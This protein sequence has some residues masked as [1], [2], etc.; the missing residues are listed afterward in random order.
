M[1]Q[2][3]FRLFIFRF[4]SLDGFS[5]FAFPLFLRN[6]TLI[7]TYLFKSLSILGDKDVKVMCPTD[8]N[9]PGYAQPHTPVQVSSFY[10][11]LFVRTGFLLFFLSLIQKTPQSLI[12]YITFVFGKRHSQCVTGF[13]H[14]LLAVVLF[15]HKKGLIVLL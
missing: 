9:L 7:F 5:I 11:L 15:C 2:G 13:E 1:L 3:G 12:P 10:A 6:I 14:L 8:F 4:T